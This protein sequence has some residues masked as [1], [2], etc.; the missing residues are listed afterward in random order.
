MMRY[1]YLP[2]AHRAEGKKYLV[3]DRP[4]G[5]KGKLVIHAGYGRLFRNA[6]ADG[7]TFGLTTVMDFEDECKVA[8]QHYLDSMGH[9]QRLK[10]IQEF[11]PGYYE[12][13]YEPPL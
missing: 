6:Y 13:T 10:W 8:A 9:G 5:L 12:V 11:S 3:Y 4:P 7:A 2:V 1:N